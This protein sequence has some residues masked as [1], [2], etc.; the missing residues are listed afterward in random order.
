MK[1]EIYLLIG[2]AS[3]GKTT[4]LKEVGFPPLS[5]ASISRDDIVDRL[6]EKCG[7]T[8]NE[9]FLFPPPDSAIGSIVPGFEKYGHVIET[10]EV[11]KHICPVSYSIVDSVNAEIHHTYYREFEEA[12]K[13]PDI[14]FITLDRVHMLEKERAVYFPYLEDRKNFFVTAVL[15]NFKDED[16]LDVICELSEIRR[17]R[18]EKTGKFKTVPR[19]VQQRMIDRYEEVTLAEGYD[20]IKMVDTLPMLRKL[21]KT[22]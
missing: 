14:N 5:T 10:H 11:A 6:T 16:T 22:N 17:K 1:K 7:F 13:N 18:I 2:P 20:S 12:V 3:I 8:Y 9:L 4:Y 15:F 19:D 21:L